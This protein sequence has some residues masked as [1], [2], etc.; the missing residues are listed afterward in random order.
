MYSISKI[1]DSLLKFTPLV[2]LVTY[3]V[4]IKQL[5]HITEQQ[6]LNTVLAFCALSFLAFVLL[7]LKN[8]GKYRVK[9]IVASISITIGIL[10]YFAFVN[11]NL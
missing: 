1:P 4:I 5:D 7:V 9:L 8:P 10:L 2:C 6:K 3:N 11:F